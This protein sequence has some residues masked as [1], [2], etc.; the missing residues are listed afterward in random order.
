MEDG[1]ADA[2]AP[3]PDAESRDATGDAAPSDARPFESGDAA[4]AGPLQANVPAVPCTG[5]IADVYTIPT[6]LP[7]LTP[8][9]RGDIVYCAVDVTYT[10]S[11]VET[12]ILAKG[13]QTPAQTGVS[14][15]RIAFRTTR[16]N[17]AD[18]VST[19][20]VYLPSVPLPLP[21]PI[22]AI[23]HPTD[24][25][26]NS[27][28]PSMDETSNQ[29]LALP[30][31]ALGYPVIV[32]DYAGLGNSALD[33]AGPGSSVQGYVDN[34][35]TGYSM[36][37]SA[38]ALRKFLPTGVFT[39]S[40]LLSGWSQGGGAV[41]AAQALAASY[42]SGGTLAGIIVF[43]AEY[44]SRLNSFGYV[45]ML[46]NPTELTIE[47]GVSDPVVAVLR[48]YA[49]DDLYLGPSH[50]TDS[51]PAAN[52]SG[53]GGAIASLCETPLGGYLQAFDLNVSDL[54]DDTFR[55]TLLA[56][57][58]GQ[59]AGCVDP[60]QS[61]YAF[62]EQNFLTAD[63][64]GPPIL[65]VQG[66]AD[67]IMP[68]ASEAACN[69]MKLEAE[70]VTP[71]VCVDPAAQHTNVVGRNQDFAMKWGRALLGGE[72]LPTCSSTGMPTCTP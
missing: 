66:L 54:I 4:D 58:N 18:G 42:G 30:W 60:G 72:S 53:I 69:I 9:T 47:T 70:G 24:G 38:R 67:I 11:E 65:Y 37:D 48:Q 61:Y 10:T 14:L 68:P 12:Q 17:G 1:G 27:C 36:L 71:Q 8:Q 63:P 59:S 46:N 31:A 3:T 19:A 41:L 45:D 5:T 28:A 15:Y 25:I 21:L 16:G 43:A 29:D 52:Q 57:I 34:H 6:G 55:T 7:A 39:Q 51:F 44:A 2:A 62:L 40:V 35:D 26:A 50:A 13:I 32:A 64:N 33:D 56:C 49:Y 23:G 20:R 22:V